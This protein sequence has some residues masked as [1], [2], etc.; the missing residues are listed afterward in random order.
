MPTT[1]EHNASALPMPVHAYNLSLATGHLVRC[2]LDLRGHCV[3]LLSSRLPTFSKPVKYLGDVDTGSNCKKI[4]RRPGVFALVVVKQ[5]RGNQGILLA[6]AVAYY[7]L[8]SLVPLLVLIVMGLS[9]VVAED[10][11]LL[12]LSEYLEFVVPGQSNALVAE[13]RTFLAHKDVVGGILLVTMLFFSAR[14]SQFSRTP[15]R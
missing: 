12:T 4:L 8:L 15:C 10:Q 2:R 9:H 1:A 6:G 14:H 3:V 5:F 13:I 7:T 11:L